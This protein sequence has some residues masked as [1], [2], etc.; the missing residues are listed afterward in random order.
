MIS[1]NLLTSVLGLQ[2]VVRSFNKNTNT[3]IYVFDAIGEKREGKINIFELAY[4]CK[5]WAVSKSYSINSYIDVESLKWISETDK[6]RYSEAFY[7]FENEPEAI[8]A[9]A[10]FILNQRTF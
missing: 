6:G 10:E 4:K 2:S 8:F 5:E 7:N 9:A 3:I 1:N